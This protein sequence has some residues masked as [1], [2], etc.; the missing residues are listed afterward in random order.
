MEESV[1]YVWAFVYCPCVHESA[2]RTVSLHKSKKGAEIAL[3]FHKAETI[4][5]WGD[6]ELS[7]AWDVQ[8]IILEN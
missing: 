4:K 1:D 3:E 2:W 5:E 8:K 7:E 6:A